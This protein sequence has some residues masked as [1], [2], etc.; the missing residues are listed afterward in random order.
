[1]TIQNI[2]FRLCKKITFFKGADQQAGDEPDRLA[3]REGRTCGF[4]RGSEVRSLPPAGH[5]T[6][7]DERQ[8]EPVQHVDQERRPAIFGDFKRG[9]DIRTHR[10]RV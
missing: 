3:E 2:A 9:L 8:H 6:Q 5:S 1:M 4:D 10:G 7:T